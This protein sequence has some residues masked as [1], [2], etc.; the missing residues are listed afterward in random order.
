MTGPDDDQLRYVAL[1]CTLKP[2]PEASS[3]DLLLDAITGELETFGY[4]GETV[5]VVDRGLAHGVTAD[6]GVGDGWPAIRQLVL[7]SQILVVG[8]PIWLGHPSSVCQ[9]V[10]ERLDAFLG[11]TDERGQIAT[12]DRV[13]LVAV[14]GNED[15]AHHVG[16]EL[17]Q[18]LNDVGFTL[19]PGAMAYWVGEA[20][21]STDLKDLDAIPDSTMGQART[22]VANAAHLV[23]HLSGAGPYP[24]L[25]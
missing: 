5:R 14:V 2:G 18:G 23:A 15:G 4:T 7:D 1:N 16:A 3:T 20:M 19:P 22:M 25:S 11:E 12:V 17:F 24:S 13:A 10:M 6:E 9:Q 8:T 21:G